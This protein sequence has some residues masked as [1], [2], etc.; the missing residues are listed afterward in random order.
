MDKI[1]IFTLDDC[2]H[3][4]SL[5]SKLNDLNISYKNIDITQNPDVWDEV[6]KQIKYQY[7]PT[8]LIRTD[9]LNLGN[10]YIPSINYQT[11]DDIIDIIKNNV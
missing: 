5:K 7:L 4:I 10:I 6:V 8:V 2:S 1:F 11:E 3:C 9:D